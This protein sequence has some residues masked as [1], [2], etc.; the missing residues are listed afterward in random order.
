MKRVMIAFIFVLLLTSFVTAEQDSLGT[1]KQGE[2]ITLL[3]ICGT[4]SYNNITS[5]VFPNKSHVEYDVS[6]TKRGAEFTFDLT[7]TD[8]LGEYTI[9][10]FGDLDGTDNAW[11]YDLYVT[12]DGNPVELPNILTHIFLMIF[13]MALCLAYHTI[14]DK[15][16]YDQWYESIRCKY[17]D[18]NKI[19][20]S[21]TSI[22][23]TFAKETF[24]IYYLLFF[25]VV[26]LLK[27]LIGDLTINS[28]LPIMDAVIVI[29]FV[30]LA[31][32]G[33]IFF[34]KIQEFIMK[35]KDDIQNDAW[36]LRHG[37]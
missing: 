9:N 19:K 10:G 15:I 28:L 34:G 17:Q 2:T 8:Q 35:L 32:V 14:S 18:K 16:D 23:Y 36:G 7:D 37:E 1:Y 21:L 26:L 29:Y 12:L 33:L 25:P 5:I 24:M 3:Q 4:C 13:F 30:G 27:Q 6:M 11:A 22:A 20:V 31:I